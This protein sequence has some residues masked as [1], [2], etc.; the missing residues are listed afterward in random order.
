MKFDNLRAYEK[1]LSSCEANQFADVYMIL[2]K[3]SFDRIAALDMTITALLGGRSPELALQ[4]FDGENLSI[5]A[6]LDELNTL[7]FLIDRK[8]VVIRQADGMKKAA[9]KILEDYL[10][11]P[12]PAVKLVMAAEAVAA[13]TNF[14]KKSEKGGVVV[15]IAQK[16]AWEKEK[17]FSDWINEQ[18]T[19][20]GKRIDPQATQLLVKQTGLDQNL[21]KMELEKLLCYV[22]E[23]PLISAKAVSDICTCVDID[24]V[25]Q[26]GEAVM[27][28]NTPKALTIASHLMTNASSVLT[29]LIP[30]RTQFH[31]DYQ[32]CSILANGGTPQD[33]SQEFRHLVGYVLNQHIEMARG[34]GM[35]RFKKGLLA[36]D[37]AERMA[38]SSTME[39]QLLLERLVIQLTI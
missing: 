12:N 34:Y 24:N 16:K 11:S 9:I 3:E 20:A 39:P 5:E 8:V 14:Y 25:W 38:K 15:S 22:G 23:E 6:L 33:I 18:V 10:E 36:L 13:N 7:P 31:T 32:I 1:H 35:E 21:L 2:S 4:S 37:E 30:L 29:V 19:K 26:F 17:D 28:R 27:R